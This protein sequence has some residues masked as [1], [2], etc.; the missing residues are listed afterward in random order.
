MYLTK[1]YSI[2]S[3]ISKWDVQDWL[4]KGLARSPL[5][6]SVI[7]PIK[8]VLPNFHQYL[9]FYEKGAS[10]FQNELVGWEKKKYIQVKNNNYKDNNLK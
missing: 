2:F 5:C 4:F 10:Y 8:F 1:E 6:Q 9:M 3:L 7:L